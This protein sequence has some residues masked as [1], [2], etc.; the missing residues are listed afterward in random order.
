M[1]SSRCGDDR[2]AR[3]CLR[4]RA[5]SGPRRRW[6]ARPFASVVCVSASFLSLLLPR[7]RGGSALAA[8]RPFFSVRV[9]RLWTLRWILSW[10]G[11]VAVRL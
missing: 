3:R 5:R 10:L 4:M 1:M 6:R 9:L 7:L 8:F 11:V 2:R